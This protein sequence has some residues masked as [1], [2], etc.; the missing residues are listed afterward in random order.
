MTAEEAPPGAITHHARLRWV[1]RFGAYGE[2]ETALARAT[3][4]TA[5]AAYLH[6]APP[7]WV[8]FDRIS[9]AIFVARPVQ[10]HGPNGTAWNVRSVLTVFPG[11]L[12]LLRRACA[13]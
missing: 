8:G 11:Q 3:D 2:L 13:D 9:S 4:V 1:E 12:A 10:S 5:F 7:A 6:I